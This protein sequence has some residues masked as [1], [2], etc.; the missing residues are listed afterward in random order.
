MA[1]AT[2]VQLALLKAFEGAFREGV[3]L[4]Q[5]LG[6]ILDSALAFFDASAVALLP[7][8]DGPPTSRLASREEAAAA[9]RLEAHLRGILKTGRPGDVVESGLGFHG[10]PVRVNDLV[11]GAFGAAMSPRDGYQG[12]GEAMRL[13]ARTISHVLERERTLATLLKRR[14]E[15][16]ALYDLAA[17]VFHSLNANEVIQLTISSLSRELGFDRVKA[18]RYEVETGEIE[19]ILS[20]GETHPGAARRSIDSEDILIR[21]LGAR[22]PVF[23]DAE[24]SGGMS[25][26]RRQMALPIQA[27]WTVFG[28]LVMSRRGSFVLT[29]QE[30]R[31]ANELAKITAGALE[32][33]RL[34]DL[35]RLNREQLELAKELRAA[36]AGLTEV[37]TVLSRAAER[38]GRHFDVEVC[39]LRLYPQGDHPGATSFHVRPGRQSI[40]ADTEIPQLLI[41]RLAPEG[42]HVLVP[43]VAADKDGPSLLFAPAALRDLERP[44]SLLAV[45]ILS[46]GTHAGMIAVVAAGNARQFGPATLRA[47]KALATELA[48]AAGSARLFER[49]R[50]SVR[51][52]DR[53][54]EIGQPLFSTFDAPRIKQILC[55]EALSL[56]GATSAHFWQTESQ[57][58]ALLASARAG[59]RRA[60]VPRSL[61]LERATH[62][63]V[64]AFTERKTI[65]AEEAGLSGT[66]SGAG[67][68]W[69]VVPVAFQDQLL[70]LLSV[71]RL[72]DAPPWDSSIG[73]RLGLLAEKGAIALHN[74]RLMAMIE[75]QTERDSQTGLSNR[76]AVLRRLDSEVRRAE[77]N[78]QSLA[79]AHVRIDG[80]SQ[81]IEHL[82][83]D[84]GDALLLKV[85]ARLMWSTR[86]MNLV[87]RDKFDCFWILIFDANR[88]Q[89]QR[90]MQ[91]IQ[92]N[93]EASLNDEP[94]ETA[95]SVPLKLTAGVSCYPEDAFG[96][97]DLVRDAEQAL[98]AASG[99]GVGRVVFFGELAE[100]AATDAAEPA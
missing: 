100:A 91:N 4:D 7:S 49:E 78:G 16:T 62:P 89:A 10:I 77:R 30:M 92:Q 98:E 94:L 61:P 67:L 50:E 79:I 44:I 28:F 34:V 53:L 46:H 93:F 12:P 83:D 23:D 71:G 24:A 37:S 14:E 1:S 88:T 86:A 15:A 18:Y 3:L 5:S 84:S 63:I 81:A 31:L 75:H 55:Q 32:R 60:D 25:R 64:R 2:V 72:L 56:V 13:Y 68:R 80:L 36:L 59:E 35:E 21:C 8:G 82:G 22:G 41:D 48:L 43:D 9:D 42:S 73:A 97:D 54:Q 45:P 26:E 20:Q 87:G 76:R 29:V 6:A 11:L 74:A 38:V 95:A 65:V 47:F 40:S 39:L 66:P 90:A 58:K 96:A 99:F 17:G 69:A 52:L 85:S 27:G 70:G 51:F 57:G 33:A 19:E